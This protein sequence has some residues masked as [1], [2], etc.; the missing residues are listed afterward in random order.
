[1]RRLAPLAAL[2]PALL[3]TGAWGLEV[4]ETV[5]QV[6]FSH[7]GTE[8]VLDD[9]TVPL[10]PGNACYNWYLR[11]EPGQDLT[12]V[13][14]LTLPEPIDWGTTGSTPDDIT[15]IEPDGR[16]AV[17]TLVVSSGDDGWLSHGWCAADGDPI[18]YHE[19]EVSLD[20]TSLATFPFNVVASAD[21]PFPTS[22][23]TPPRA[24]RTVRDSW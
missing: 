10:L 1:M 17:T 18:G 5:F 8:Y 13:E 7:E 6:S 12:L 3:S 2:A 19:I 23:P 24:Q 22:V 9:A 14:R 20:G 4:N 16:V 11:T 15:Q 21:Y